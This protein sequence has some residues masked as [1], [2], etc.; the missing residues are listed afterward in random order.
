[1]ARIVD[2]NDVVVLET[3]PDHLLNCDG[4]DMLADEGNEDDEDAARDAGDGSESDSDSCDDMD[5][6]LRPTQLLLP[7]NPAPAPNPTPAPNPAPNPAPATPLPATPAHSQPSNPKPPESKGGGLRKQLQ[8]LEGKFAA[9]TKKPAKSAISIADR[10]Y[11]SMHWHRQRFAF[12]L[13]IGIRNPT[14]AAPARPTASFRG[15]SPL[16]LVP[17]PG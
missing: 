14:A 2:E 16:A 13:P 17:T 1:M 12:P 10:I 15:L 5:E 11:C 3:S 7:P 9:A 8:D 6:T 4:E